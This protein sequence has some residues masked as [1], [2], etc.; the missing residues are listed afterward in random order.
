MI[1]ASQT[2]QR[3]AA[4]GL[5]SDSSNAGQALSLGARRIHHR[6]ILYI[7]FTSRLNSSLELN[8]RRSQEVDAIAHICFDT[9]AP[10]GDQESAGRALFSFKFQ[11]TLPLQTLAFLSFRSLLR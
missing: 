8:Y 9:D 5:G 11:R 2:Y 4:H 10:T 7:G 6:A 3:Q 1:Y